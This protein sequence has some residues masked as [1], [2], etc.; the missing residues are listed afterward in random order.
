MNK[1]NKELI[2][3]QSIIY[4]LDVCQTCDCVSQF[5]GKTGVYGIVKDGVPKK[6]YCSFEGSYTWTVRKMMNFNDF[7]KKNIE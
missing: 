4:F 6:I 7:R 3:Y 2:K 5:I 1:S